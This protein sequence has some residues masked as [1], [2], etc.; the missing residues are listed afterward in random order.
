MI[1]LLINKANSHE[2]YQRYKNHSSHHDVDISPENGDCVGV[3]GVE[4]KT[5]HDI[6]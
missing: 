6:A 4:Y 5:T 3:D 1:I 2:Q